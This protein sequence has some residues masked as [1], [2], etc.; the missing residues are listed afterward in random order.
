MPR[1][2]SRSR[3]TA[4]IPS[5][6][7]Q[8]SHEPHTTPEMPSRAPMR[9]SR[10]RMPSSRYGSSPV[11]SITSSPPRAEVRAP[12]VPASAASRLTQPPKVMPRAVP[13]T[14]A[15]AASR[16][17]VRTDS[18]SNRVERRAWRVASSF[19]KTSVA[20]IGPCS[21]ENPARRAN[22]SCSTVM[23]L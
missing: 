6:G 1:E 14:S 21:V 13:G 20:T 5:Y 2:P 11:S 19:R 15:A 9:S 18:G 23:S 16:P 4:L 3:S 17:R 10:V 8:A 12:G 22:A 7:P